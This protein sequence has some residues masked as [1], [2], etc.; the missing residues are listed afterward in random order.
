MQEFNTVT[1]QTSWG[2]TLSPASSQTVTVHA[3]TFNSVEGA[4]TVNIPVTV[5]GT[6]AADTQ[7]PAGN[8]AVSPAGHQ[9]I[10]VIETPA[11]AANSVALRVVTNATPTH[12]WTYIPGTGYLQFTLA[13]QTPD[14]KTWEL[15]YRP[16]LYMPHNAVISAN[17]AWAV[18][19]NVVTYNY[20]VLLSAPF[21]APIVQIQPAI[22]RVS[23]NP[24]TVIRDQ[25]TTLTVRTNVDVNYVWAEVDDRRVNATR[26]SSSAT[27]RTWSIEIRP[28]RTQTV[29]IYANSTNTVQG[30]AS[31][32]IRVTVREAEV[33]I[34]RA[35]L[36][37]TRIWEDEGTSIDV[38]T[39]LEA[40]HVWAIVDGRRVNATRG[41]ASGNERTWTIDIRPRESQTIAIYANTTTS[42]SNA[43]RTTVRITVDPFIFLN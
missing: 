33:A 37:R 6:A 42:E 18:D 13:T 39:N 31:D 30:A 32:S 2:L 22:T 29:A 3:N 20:M 11:P 34:I 7:P 38:R 23:M 12:V 21:V 26:T 15:T 5:A 10:S 4:A 16:A 35:D 28:D 1:G 19:Q 24:T 9:I 14:T 25:R 40:E 8:Q 41:A 36:G 17:H 43:A 27:A